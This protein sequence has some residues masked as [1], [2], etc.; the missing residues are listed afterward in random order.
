VAALAVVLLAGAITSPAEAADLDRSTILVKFSIPSQ[1]PGILGTYGDRA[2]ARLA[3]GTLLV[4]LAA[5]RTSSTAVASYSRL[6]GVEYAEPNYVATADLGSPNDPSFS[7]QWSL[8]TISAVSGWSRL[9]GSYPTSLG[10]PTIA[11]VDTG[12]QANHPDLSGRVLTGANC[13]GASGTCTS[14]NS[15]DD[16]NHGTHVAGIAAA[17]TNNGVGIAGVALTSRI[18]PVKALSA[19]GSGY[20]SAI[21]AGIDWAVANGA[22]VIN[23]SLSGT[24]SSTTLCNAVARA[25]SANVVVVTAAGNNGSSAPV[26]PAA[27]SGSIGVAATTSA[28]VAASYSNFGS[29][30]VFVSAP[31]SSIYSTIAGSSYVTYS[32]TSMAAPHVAGLAALLRAQTPGLSVSSLKTVLATTSDK[33]GGVGY[34]SDPYGTCAGCTWSSAYGYGRINLDRALGGSAPL[35]PPPPPPTDT[36]PP[37]PPAGLSATASGTSINLSWTASTDSV[38]VTG[39]EVERCQGTDCSGFAL[40]ATVTTTSM[41]DSGVS[42]STA[43][44]YRVRAK[45]LAGNTSPYSNTASATTATPPPPTPPPSSLTTTFPTAV[46][47]VTGTTAG[48]SAASLATVDQSYYTVRSAFLSSASWYG[49]FSAAANASDFKVTY[50][51]FAS[52]TCTLSLAVYRWTTSTW[53]TVGTSRSI[54]TSQV[55]IADQAPSASVP[56]S[57]LRSSTGQVRVRVTCSAFTFSTYTSS[58]NMLQLSYRS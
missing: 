34:G 12:V 51:G 47:V 31:G 40:I 6:F 37:T 38:G 20:Y 21:A 30:N 15:A 29:P 36:T 27:C 42:A 32:G 56:P 35:P 9:F 5:G 28:D 55:T 39:Y 10:G 45:D 44:S 26:Y 17:S 24:A 48:G 1:V 46:T 58:G 23:M 11:I 53:V 13:V 7:S 41:V 4:R 14:G 52:R 18:L 3:D 19:S 54:G 57:D 2:S 8:A 50:T 22:Q 33:I 25:V 43:Y 16:N 49:T